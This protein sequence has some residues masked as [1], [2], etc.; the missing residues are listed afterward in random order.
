MKKLIFLLFLPLLMSAQ[1][2]FDESFAEKT[3]RFD[4]FHTGNKD[5]E[6]IVFDKILEEP[7][8]GG[9]KTHLIDD[10]EYGNYMFS[11]T[12]KE[13]G[14]K[15]YS[16]GFS[17]LFQEWQTTEEAMKY[18]RVFH[19]SV[20]FP[21]PK[22][23]CVIEIYKRDRKNKFQKIFEHFI[24]PTDYFISKERKLL[25]DNFKVSYA[26]NP[27]EKLD[28]V[29]IPD[30]YSADE[31]EKFRKDCMRFADTLFSYSP[32]GEIKDE[33]NIWGVSAFSDEPGVDIPA[34]NIWKNSILNSTYYTFDSERYLMT[35][36]YHAVR[37]LASNAPYDQIYILVNS[38]KYGGGAIYNYY[39]TVAVDCQGSGRVFIHEF[40][41]GVAGLA[42]EYFT[43]DVAYIGMYPLDVE[44]WEANIT[45]MI[46]FDSKWKSLLTE[47]TPIPTPVDKEKIVTIS[48]RLKLGV[49]EGGGYITKGVYRPSYDSIMK[50]LATGEFNEAAKTAIVKVLNMYIVK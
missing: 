7:N 6:V 35:S 33:I 50:T 8:W 39:S 28:I 24:N 29:F 38:D 19:G 18:D 40:G 9:T 43:D 36:D 22:K 3:M 47:D 15:I 46:D 45:T 10:V 11:V 2:N 30:G 49:Y 1:I 16:R 14:I 44:P 21:Y 27:A 20:I 25:Y 32:F 26:G 48:D 17:T 12:E 23:N 37:D 42:D 5:K 31:E 41:H 34:E 13:S 4:F